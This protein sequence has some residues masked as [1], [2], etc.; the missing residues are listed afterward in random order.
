[1]HRL[2]AA[3]AV[4]LL[5][6]HA[7][8]TPTLVYDDP[9]LHAMPGDTLHIGATLSLGPDDNPISTDAS[10][11]HAVD[12]G[13]GVSYVAY[14]LALQQPLDVDSYF[15]GSPAFLFALHTIWLPPATNPVA[16]LNLGPGQ[17][18]HLDL[19][20]IVLDGTIPSGSYTTEVGIYN[21]CGGVG[22]CS[23]NPFGLPDFADAGPLTINVAIPA[24]ASGLM[25]LAGVAVIAERHRRRK[26]A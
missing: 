6:G 17:S 12:F 8:A 21:R 18:T 26:A 15:F 19:G 5:A 3:L 1:M 10:G 14:A 4:V 25:L 22:F 16:D 9:V 7:Q 23:L 13:G 2:L 11:V 20:E 24:P